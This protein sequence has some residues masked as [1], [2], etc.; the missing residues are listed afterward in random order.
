MIFRSFNIKILLHIIVNIFHYNF[1]IIN[2]YIYICVFLRV[3]F[4]FFTFQIV[5][6]HKSYYYITLKGFCLLSLNV[7]MYLYVYNTTLLAL[8]QQYKSRFWEKI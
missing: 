7:L 4:F 1:I 2:I 3:I 5:S 8:F 6:Q